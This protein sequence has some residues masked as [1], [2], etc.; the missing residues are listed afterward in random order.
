MRNVLLRPEDPLGNEAEWLLQQM[1]AE[2]RQRYGDVIS[3]SAPLPKNE[4]L[5]AR[6]IFLIARVR[7]EPVGCAA[8]RPLDAITG[9]IRRMYVVRSARRRGIARCLLAELERIAIDFG[10]GA[11]RLETGN[12]QPEAIAL[13]ESCGF[14]RIPPYGPHVHDPLSICFEKSLQPSSK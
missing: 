4:P 14:H 7:D 6:S 12:R 1:S 11:V 8:L 3:P 5:T 10:Y 2:A 9:E 13:Y